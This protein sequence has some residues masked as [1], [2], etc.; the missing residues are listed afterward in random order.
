MAITKILISQPKP[1]IG[2]SPYLD[3]ADKYKI[4][5]SFQPFIK[6]E[7]LSSLEF[8]E[9]KIALLEHTAIIFN[10][11]TAVE[12]FFSLS[13]E[14]RLTMSDEMKYF[15]MNEQIAN[16]LQK[17]ITVRKR[18]VHIPKLSSIDELGKLIAK[19]PKEKYFMPIPQGYK[20]DFVEKL[21]TAKIS[22]TTGTMFRTV[23]VELPT[24]IKEEQFDLIVLFTPIGVQSF[25]ENFPNCDTSKTKLAAFGPKTAKAITDAGYALELSAPSPSCP[26]MPKALEQYLA[27][28]KK[29]K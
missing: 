29:K 2:R 14:L 28:N 1:E 21:E 6:V 25:Q 24:E 19:H 10:T 12:H 11:R 8:R 3:I 20:R 7:T 16:Y 4:D 17:F 23:P 9:Q 18:K 27:K 26:S 5:L 13:K 15:C 22:V